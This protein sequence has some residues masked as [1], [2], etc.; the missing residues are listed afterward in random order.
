MYII[1]LITIYTNCLNV[2][3]ANSCTCFL[4]YFL[5]TQCFNLFY[6]LYLHIIYGRLFQHHGFIGYHYDIKWT[7]DQVLHISKH[8]GLYKDCPII[9]ARCYLTKQRM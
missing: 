6:E 5:R 4:S 8:K 2:K 7:N 1:L 9:L 3:K